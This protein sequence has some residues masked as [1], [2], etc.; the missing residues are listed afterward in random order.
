MWKSQNRTGTYSGKRRVCENEMREFEK[1]K[2]DA[3]SLTL[4]LQNFGHS[5]AEIYARR[6]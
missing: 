3:V 5:I 1:S 4:L 2:I 6:V